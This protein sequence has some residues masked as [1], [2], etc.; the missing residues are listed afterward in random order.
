MSSEKQFSQILREWAEAFMHRSFKEFKSFMDEEGLSPT[1]VNTLMRLYHKGSCGVS[2]IG[3]FTGVTNAAASQMIDR[4][5]QMNLLERV[6]SASDRR[7][8]QL[9]LTEKGKQLVHRGIETR[10]R[11]FE[12]LTCEITAEQQKIV[13]DGLTIL[14][15][16]AKNR[17]A[18]SRKLE[19]SPR[20]G[21]STGKEK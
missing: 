12:D 11:W 7:Y 19:R 20:G 3:E 10:Q 8:K 1:Q 15:E 9:S 13:A 21:L 4:L 14:T 16:A 6:E 18:N 17:D 5:V 2:D